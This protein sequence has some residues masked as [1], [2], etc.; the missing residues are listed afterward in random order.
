MRKSICLFGTLV[1]CAS[2]IFSAS[3]KSNATV[4]VSVKSADLKSSSGFLSKKT[5]SVSYG[6]ALVVIES[7]SSKSRV[8]LSSNASVTGWVSNGNLT[9]KKITKSG[10]SSVAASSNELAL[11]GKGFSEEAENAFRSSNGNLNYTEVD[12]IEK[13]TV[14][15]SEL[16]NFITEGHLNGGE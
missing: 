8:R 5:G 4:Y 15:D 3:F 13:I 6:D 11:A 2:F 12:R 10:N 16:H 1:F 14:S 9:S 7:N